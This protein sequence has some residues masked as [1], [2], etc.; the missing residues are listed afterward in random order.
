MTHGR[1][2]SAALEPRLRP[3]PGAPAIVVLQAG[4]LNTGVFDPFESLIPI[5]RRHDAWVHVDGAFGLVGRCLAAL[6]PSD[7]RRG[8]GRF[9]GHRRPQVAERALRLR[10]RLRRRSG[11]AARGDVVSGV[12][13]GLRQ[14]RSR[15]DRLEPRV[16][17]ARARAFRLMP[18]SASWAAAASP[19]SSSAA[20]IMRALS[21]WASADCPA[22]RCLWT[23]VINQGLVRFLDP[24]GDDHDRRTDEI[25][26]AR[27]GIGRGV[28]RRRNLARQARHAHQRLQLD[29]D[30]SR[31]G[32]RHR[33]RC[34]TL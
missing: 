1:L 24:R 33:R 16:V 27:A 21:P 30:R 29:D 11:G 23:P 20:A 15:S 9:L 7:G 22:P 14:R 17:A 5:A 4:E 19:K 10:L 13:P 32:A 34:D 28:L 18:P 25:I 31:C 12:V 2:D 3:L 8:C 26:A 6:P